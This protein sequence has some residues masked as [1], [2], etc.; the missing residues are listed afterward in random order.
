M[1][2]EIIDTTGASLE[3]STDGAA[4]F[5]R[6][7]DLNGPRG[8]G[9]YTLRRVEAPRV[10][11]PGKTID[12]EGAA[13][14]AATR[15]ILTGSG[16]AAPEAWFAAGTDM[17]PCGEAV[18]R[19]I[20]QDFE[21]QIPFRDAAE[22]AIQ[23]IIGQNRRDVIVEPGD[24]SRIRFEDG[25][26]RV[27]GRKARIGMTALRDLMA[28]FSE[29]FPAAGRW[30]SVMGRAALEAAIADG[31]DRWRGQE[32]RAVQLRI[33]DHSVTGEPIVW[34]VV[35]A[36]YPG[37]PT[38]ADAILRAMLAQV[39]GD[40]SVKGEIVVD[41]NSG[42]MTARAVWMDRT[43]KNPKVGDVFQATLVAR[44]RDDAKGAFTGNGGITAIRCINCSLAT[45]TFGEG[46]GIHRSQASIDK[47]VKSAFSGF[48]KQAD[49]LLAHWGYLTSAALEV[50]GD[51]GEVIRDF[52][53]AI[54]SLVEGDADVVA[55]LSGLNIEAE[56][57]ANM[58][59]AAYVGEREAGR[60]DGT[61]ADVVRIMAKVAQDRR[62]SNQ[63]R[64][65]M[66]IAS[67][68]LIPILARRA[69]EASA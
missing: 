11:I 43:I 63:Q 22:L 15:A 5:A 25:W 38:D 65:E 60:V 48:R 32:D 26:L 40:R 13:R 8:D 36:Q 61:L 4:L 27:N 34:A 66:E 67:G 10:V 18:F 51:D 3:T 58:M 54:P 24:V 59:R 64:I 29:V 21:R 17:L 30:A 9:G 53:R 62:L 12:S 28:R 47:A 35:G 55:A 50:E 44:T 7:A 56:S 19:S 6:L 14:I 23:G 31:F 46:R 57:A 49:G 1:T 41:P 42:E 20:A 37:R 52:E 33:R 68:R 39:G 45:S 69:Q 2:Y 16:I